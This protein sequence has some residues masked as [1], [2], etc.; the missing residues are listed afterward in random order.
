VSKPIQPAL[1]VKRKRRK[2]AKSPHRTPTNS[3]PLSSLNL[4]NILSH[5]L[6]IRSAIKELST[7]LKRLENILDSLYK[8]FE[9][10]QTFLAQQQRSPGRPLLRL[11]PPRP[12]KKSPFGWREDE[13]QSGDSPSNPPAPFPG[14][15]DI[16]QIM[17]LLQSPLVQNL[18]SQWIQQLPSGEGQ[19]RKQG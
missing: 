1:P 18:L 4:A 16:N 8:M 15:I 9:I 12:Q 11:V 19:E 10:A 5:F 14:N 13:S 2:P 7:S 6:T 3:T 17:A